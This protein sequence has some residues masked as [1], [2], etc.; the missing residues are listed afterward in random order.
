MPQ[1]RNYDL[2]TDLRTRVKPRDASA[3]KNSDPALDR[4]SLTER[5]LCPVS[6]CQ[7]TTLQPSNS[8]FYQIVIF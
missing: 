5:T 6:V 3:P 2:L 4:R 1:V 8:R 7:A